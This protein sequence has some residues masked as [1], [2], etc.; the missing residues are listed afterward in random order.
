VTSNKPEMSPQEVIDWR[1]RHKL[2]QEGLAKLLWV[3][4]QAVD[5][6][7]RG[8]RRVS[9]TTVRLLKLF[10]KYPQLIKEY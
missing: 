6:W 5:L 9:P 1:E 3:S 10:D 4:W 7:E 2:S 8:E